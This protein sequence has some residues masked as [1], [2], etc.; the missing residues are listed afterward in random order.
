MKCQ[1]KKNTIQL[2]LFG[3]Q[4]ELKLKL[5]SMQSEKAKQ[6]E[7]GSKEKEPKMEDALIATNSGIWPGIAQMQSNATVVEKRA[8]REQTV[9]TIPKERKEDKRDN[10]TTK[11]HIQAKEVTTKDNER[12]ATTHGGLTKEANKAKG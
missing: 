11:D 7:K 6:W 8:T 1:K 5:Q 9:G 3:W 12:E 10:L 4:T 2:R